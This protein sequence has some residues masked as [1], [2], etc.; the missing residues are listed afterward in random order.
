[1]V[2]AALMLAAWLTTPPSIPDP[3]IFPGYLPIPPTS[4]DD[5]LTILPNEPAENAFNKP[6]IKQA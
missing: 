6:I 1:M 4:A 2:I 3:L 5:R